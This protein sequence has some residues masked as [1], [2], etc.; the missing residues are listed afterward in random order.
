MKGKEMNNLQLNEKSLLYH[1]KQYRMKKHL[2]YLQ[3][4]TSTND[5]AKKLCNENKG[6][7]TL[8][9]ADCQTAG[10]GRTGRSFSS[11]K[12]KGIYFSAVY[13]LN[14]N[15]KN[16]EILSSV[17]GLAV[18]DTLYNMFNIDAKIKWP[19]DILIDG[20]KVCGILCE[21]V[22]FNN[23]PKF[24]VIGIGV[25]IEKCDFDDE[26]QYIATSVGDNYEG[27]LDHN[28]IL[29][30]IVNN[31][32]RYI[33]RNNALTS[34]NNR[35][36]ILR[37]KAHSATLEKMIRVI[38]PDGEYDARAL[39]IDENGGLVVKSAV[40]IRTLTSGEVVHIR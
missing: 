29:I 39:D 1:L 23:R 40:D 37:L 27:E 3:E 25:N 2:T 14:G 22:N 10:K 26:L 35:N 6:R 7:G 15:E 20:K 12:G 5:V 33:I 28:E 4:T 21:I 8:V 18:R 31:L 17:A 19:N 32:D 11:P 30:D 9:A 13:E 24:A 36:I 38:T 34:A 16:L